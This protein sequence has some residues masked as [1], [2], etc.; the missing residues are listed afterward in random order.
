MLAPNWL[1]FI[2]SNY[3]GEVLVATL[4]H[5]LFHLAQPANLERHVA[6]GL[7]MHFARESP[8][9]P[10]WQGHLEH[11]DTVLAQPTSQRELQQA[12]ARAHAE[13]AALLRREPVAVLL[14]RYEP[15]E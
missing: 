4:R 5:E 10:L 8:Q 9:A 15:P 13:V 2:L 1:G 12:M 7:A 3:R 14:R 6:E 11:L